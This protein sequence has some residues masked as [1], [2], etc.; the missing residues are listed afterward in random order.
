MLTIKDYEILRSRVECPV[1]ERIDIYNK[2][3][4]KVIPRK[5]HMTEN[6]II[7]LR[8][9]WK[10]NIKDI[11]VSLLSKV[12]NIF[13][14]PYRETGIYYWCVQSLFLL[15]GNEW[16]PYPL[17]RSKIEDGMIKE[18]NKR[19]ENAW[20]KFSHK[21]SSKDVYGR[22]LMNY[23]ILQRLGG[24]NPYGYKLKQLCSCIDIKRDYTKMY[25]FK[26]N[27]NFSDESLVKPIYDIYK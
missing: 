2:L 27:T 10:N 16:H 12:S 19:K 11:D 7:K 4:H 23:K 5:Y 24:I 21:N 3:G 8:S 1:N 18:F 26:L 22:I 20:E 17:V 14:N 6:N 13:F 9:K 15:G 25:Y